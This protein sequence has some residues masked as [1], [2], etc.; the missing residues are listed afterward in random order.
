MPCTK[1][2]RLFVPRA[3]AA[4][5]VPGA[6][7]PPIWYQPFQ[8]VPLFVVFSDQRAPLLPRAKTSKY[9]GARD[10]AAGDDVTF[11]PRDVGAAQV[12]PVQY[13]YHREPFVP[14]TKRLKLFAFCAV[15]AGDEVMG[16]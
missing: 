4:G 10:V 9:P 2:S 3:S 8:E 13:L 15:T 6:S 12:V 7:C 1:T 16:T 11:P 14:F 5:P